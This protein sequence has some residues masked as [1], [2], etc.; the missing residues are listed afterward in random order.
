MPN[1]QI[2]V[3]RSRFE[4]IGRVHQQASIADLESPQDTA[5]GELRM[6]AGSAADAV[7]HRRFTCVF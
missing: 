7:H 4:L 2:E 1:P 6:H 3:G 5:R